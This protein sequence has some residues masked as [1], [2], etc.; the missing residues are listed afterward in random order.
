L[1]GPFAANRLKIAV[2]AAV[3]AGRARQKAFA[4]GA[5]NG[6][7]DGSKGGPSPVVEGDE[8]ARKIACVGA[9]VEFSAGDGSTARAENF[10]KDERID[11][12]LKDRPPFG[13]YARFYLCFP[14]LVVD[15]DE[16]AVRSSLDKVNR[17]PRE[18]HGGSR[19]ISRNLYRFYD[20]SWVSSRL[21]GEAKGEFEVEGLGRVGDLCVEPHLQIADHFMQHVVPDHRKER[22]ST[23]PS[24]RLFFSENLEER[25]KMCRPIVPFQREFSAI[26]RLK[27]EA[28]EDFVDERAADERIDDVP[29]RTIFGGREAEDRG[30]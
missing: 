10:L 13:N 11:D 5:I 2:T 14:G 9:V 20:A 26:S 25:L 29:D 27:Q 3:F 28:K 16:G 17:T 21:L 24:I 7:G 15:G 12:R 30:K 4:E 18:K 22:S 1:L 6:A 8:D 23:G 19:A